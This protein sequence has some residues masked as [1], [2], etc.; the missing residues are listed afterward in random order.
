MKADGYAIPHG[1][2]I[3]IASRRQLP[4]T[5]CRDDRRMIAMSLGVQQLCSLSDMALFHYSAVALTAFLSGA[6]GVAALRPL[7]AFPNPIFTANSLRCCA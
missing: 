1:Y 3:H 7:P 4:N 6:F 2:A 5:S